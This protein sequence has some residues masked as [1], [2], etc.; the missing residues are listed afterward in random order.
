MKMVLFVFF[1]CSFLSASPEA[2]YLVVSQDPS[3]SMSVHWIEKKQTASFSSVLYRKEGDLEWRKNSS[4]SLEVLGRSAEAS[5]YF[6]KKVLLTD[7]EAGAFYDFCLEGEEKIYHFRTLPSKIN[8][9]LKIAIGGD[10]SEDFFLY[11][12]MNRI[13]AQKN[14]DFVVLAGDIAYACNKGVSIG[15]HGSVGKWVDFFVEWQKS[16][17]AEGDRMIPV[18]PLVGNHD[19]TSVD[20]AEKGKNA[21]YLKFFPS[22]QGLT[23][24]TIEIAGT[25][26]LF[27][28]DTGHVFSVEGKQMQWLEE[29]FKKKNH[30][31]WKIPIYHVAAYPSVYSYG[32]VNAKNIRKWWVPLFERYGVKLAFEHHNHAYKRTHALLSNQ[33]DPAGVVYIGDGGWGASPRGKVENRFYLAKGQNVSCFSLLQVTPSSLLVEAFDVDGVLIDTWQTEDR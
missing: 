3:H 9:P 13:A 21:F 30:I 22:E 4:Y 18:V 1:F 11:S 19:V 2:I 20:R 23:Y 8:A 7:L 16:M 32:S 15:S 5:L 12:K 31:S 14:P 26:S 25:L 17:V 33:I 28:L 24:R 10:F 27:L 29:E 6:V